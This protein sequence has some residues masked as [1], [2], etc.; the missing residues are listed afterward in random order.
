MFSAYLHCCTALL[1]PTHLNMRTAPT[2]LWSADELIGPGS[3]STS[4]G[5]HHEMLR[6]LLQPLFSAEA[7][8]GSLPVVV[9]TVERYLATWAAA[10]GVVPGSDQIKLMTFA[11]ILQVGS[12]TGQGT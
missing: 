10:E 6:G 8:A 5:R 9:G 3:L 11:I 4:V 12:G 7:L 2:C 1:L